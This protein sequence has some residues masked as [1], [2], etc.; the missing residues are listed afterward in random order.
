[1][2]FQ[3]FTP[4]K[5]STRHC[6]YIAS[7]SAIKSSYK[8]WRKLY[9]CIQAVTC[10]SQH[11]LL[12]AELEAVQYSYSNQKCVDFRYMHNFNAIVAHPVVVKHSNS[13]DVCGVLKQDEYP[14]LVLF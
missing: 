4:T 9:V 13:H 5:C 8:F 12:V 14:M 7:E 2:F 1:M 11:F 10:M 6:I 3:K